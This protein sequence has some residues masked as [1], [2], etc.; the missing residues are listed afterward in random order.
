MWAW[1][2]IYT[3]LCMWAQSLNHVWLFVTPWT[4]TRSLLCPWDFPGENT[5]V[6]CH[7]LLQGLFP[8][9]GSNTHLLHRQEDSL[10]L[11][12]LG[13]PICVLQLCLTLCDP[14]ALSMGFSRQEYWSGLLFP[15]PGDLPDPGIEPASP[16][17]NLHWQAGSLPL[18][19]IWEASSPV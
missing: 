2:F 1:F 10:P 5:G 3:R 15:P 19:A 11:S 17:C 9:Q 14:V 4:V 7:F 8:N 13:S 12:R 6:G 16:M 18:A